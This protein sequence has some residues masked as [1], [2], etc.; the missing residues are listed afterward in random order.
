LQQLLYPQAP[1]PLPPESFRRQQR[2][3]VPR[4]AT[5]MII[6]CRRRRCRRR[7]RHPLYHHFL[8]HPCHP[9]RHDRHPTIWR[10]SIRRPRSLSPPRS[11]LMPVTITTTTTTTTT[12]R[13]RRRGCDCLWGIWEMRWEMP[14]CSRT[15]LHGIRA[16]KRPGSF[17]MSETKARPRDSGSCG[18]LSPSKGPGPNGKWTKRGSNPDRSGS[19]STTTQDLPTRSTSNRDR[20]RP[21][22]Q[23]R[24]SRDGAI[25]DRSLFLLSGGLKL[26]VSSSYHCHGN[27]FCQLQ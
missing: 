10:R 18:S 23:G 16:A 3:P 6:L 25:G 4:T 8:H 15:F 26:S 27:R 24:S 12:F 14:N 22:W 21:F 19:K 7:R 2:R 17:A 5:I 11:L 9:T 1:S 13:G 20:T